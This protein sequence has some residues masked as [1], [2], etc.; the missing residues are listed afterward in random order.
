[1]KRRLTLSIMSGIEDGNT[2]E[3]R[4]E[5]DGRVDGGYWS[6]SIG[7]REDNDVCLKYDTFVSRRH[8]YLHWRNQ[9]W[10]LED[11]GSTNGTFLEN[12]EDFFK[13]IEV[14]G[15]VQIAQGQLFK[16]GKTWMRIQATDIYGTDTT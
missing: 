8:G 1:M 14:Q 16:V 2:Y 3:V 10:W 5:Y 6:L 13:E 11:D 4:S 7:R 15:T 12:D 9:S